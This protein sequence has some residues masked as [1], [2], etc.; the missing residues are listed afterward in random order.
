MK[1]LSLTLLLSLFCIGSA[2][3]QPDTE[4]DLLS[5]L[6]D[7][8]SV[9]TKELVRASFKANRVINSHSLENTPGGVLDVKISHR[10]GQ[11]TSGFSNFF[12]L[13]NAS[14]RLGIDM[15]ITDRLMVGIGRSSYGKTVDGFIK[16]KLLWQSKGKKA[17]PV[18]VLLMSAMTI[19]TSEWQYPD[20]ENFFTSRLGYTHQLLIGRKFSEGFS[21]QLMPTLVHRNLVA[22]NAEKNSVFA[23]GAAARQKITKRVALTA[24]YYYVM[25][26]QVDE[27]FKNS[28]SVGVDIET[29]GHVFQLHASNSQPMFERGFITE[30]NGDWLK[31]NI[32]VGFNISRVFNIYTPKP[33]KID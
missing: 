8:D 29:G 7:E 24:E 11:L 1:N 14:I 32:Y 9:E 30:T 2:W 26:N 6:G 31:G 20:R 33:K 13:D 17:M 25:P 4:G 22:T 21:A 15:G 19:N 18:S 12:G 28:L 10:F 3:A 5:L 16:Y 27:R 23:I